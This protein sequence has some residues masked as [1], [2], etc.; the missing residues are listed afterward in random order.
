MADV[1]KLSVG[2]EE[3]E[4]LPDVVDEEHCDAE[5]VR[6][7]IGK[8]DTVSDARAVTTCEDRGVKGAVTR[9]HGGRIL[10]KSTAPQG[11]VARTRAAQRRADAQWPTWIS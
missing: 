6:L 1:D 11:S 10:G 3:G 8:V 9:G 4:R 2:D 7:S 5:L